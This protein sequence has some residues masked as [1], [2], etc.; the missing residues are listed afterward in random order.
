MEVQ[1]SKLESLKN[2]SI[3]EIIRQQLDL[4]EFD[5]TLK[6]VLRNIENKNKEVT[7]KKKFK[8]LFFCF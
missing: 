7:F 8:T 1:T 4:V 5:S 3:S 2:E 6:K